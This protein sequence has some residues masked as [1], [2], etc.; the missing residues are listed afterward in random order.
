M[1]AEIT[2]ES[3]TST[4]ASPPDT[5]IPASHRTAGTVIRTAPPRRR[6]LERALPGRIGLRKGAEDAVL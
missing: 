3:L 1:N 4:V 6:E 5:Q 2:G